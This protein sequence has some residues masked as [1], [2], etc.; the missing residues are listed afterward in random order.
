MKR[1][2]TF[3]I[4]VSAVAVSACAPDVPIDIVGHWT[5]ADPTYADR[6]FRIAEDSVFLEVGPGAVEG[7]R[8]RSVRRTEQPGR[9]QFDIRYENRYRTYDMRIYYHPSDGVRLA[10]RPSILWSRATP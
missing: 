2:A 10:S 7:Y 5:T 6:G 1:F 3:A 4:L 9:T 8:V